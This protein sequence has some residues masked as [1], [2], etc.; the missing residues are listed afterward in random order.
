MKHLS[1]LLACASL[2]SHADAQ[3]A[4]SLGAD[5]ATFD[6]VWKIVDELHFD[7]EH[8]G[9]DWDAAR[10]EYRP[11]AEAAENRQAS[12]EI[13]NEM[14][15][16]LGQSHFAL[17][18]QEEFG[19]GDE[20]SPTGT[21]GFDVRVRGDEVWVNRV[22]PGSP[23]NVAGVRRGWS[24][25]AIDG[26][27]TG[28]LLAAA[29]KEPTRRPET[30]HRS[31][32]LSC[33]DGPVGSNASFTFE[34]GTGDIIDPIELK[35]VERDALPFDVP[36]LPRFYLTMRA[37]RR[38]RGGHSMGVL[39]FSNWLTGIE[40][41]INA[42]LDAM[43]GCHGV[44]LDLRGNTGGDGLM[45]IRV[46]GHFFDQPTSLGTQVARRG[47]FE[48]TVGP[49]GIALL[50]PLVIL[51]DETTG[52][53][54]EIFAGGMQALGRARVIGEASTGAALPARLTRLP[55]G[56]FLLH[57]IGDFLTADGESMEGGGV[58]PDQVLPVRRADLL[59]GVDAP[60]EAALD[61]I[62]EQAER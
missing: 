51:T 8:N 35:R 26:E 21:L 6:K 22:E 52:S 29:P 58:Q 46:A 45:A 30:A 47:N 62:A 54:S 13:I 43:A 34:S 55:S 10:L 41:E 20:N 5:L 33:I 31:V 3:E 24:L 42:A 18:A 19:D 16:L 36:G 49:R 53:A 57:A 17:I 7:A 4:S 12:R 50:G 44:V 38:E 40:K 61:W 59:A 2:A 32:L 1:I 39:R 23:A 15:G 14:L 48:Y 60:L 9:V 56:D 25:T 28:D 27:S 11:H 37:E